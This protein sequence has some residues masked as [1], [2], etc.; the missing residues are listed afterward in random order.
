MVTG[1]NGQTGPP[2]TSRAVE[3][4]SGADDAVNNLCLEEKTVQ[5]RL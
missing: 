3:D 2:V 4:P 5:D 1:T